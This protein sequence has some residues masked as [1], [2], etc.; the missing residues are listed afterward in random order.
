[1]RHRGPGV[2]TCRRLPGRRG[3]RRRPRWP[4]SRCRGRR[5]PGWKGTR[6]MRPPARWPGRSRSAQRRRLRRPRSSRG[7]GDWVC[8][9][10][11]PNG[12][13]RLRLR[14]AILE[15]VRKV[16][17]MPGCVK[18]PLRAV[19]ERIGPYQFLTPRR[20]PERHPG[21]PVTLGTRARETLVPGRTIAGRQWYRG[22]R[23][24]P[25]PHRKNRAKEASGP[26]R[27]RGLHRPR[28]CLPHVVPCSSLFP[29][30]TLTGSPPTGSSL[31]TPGRRSRTPRP[32]RPGDWYPGT[33][34][35]P[36]IPPRSQRSGLPCS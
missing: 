1:V 15:A 6:Q 20:C 8:S 23:L 14:A 30:L 10:V 9:W 3:R 18:A 27:G 12:R 2:R 28:R 19:A 7:D 34:H 17:A 5:L 33:S 29:L 13:D 35:P 25:P 36:K 21:S 16:F 11:L 32:G 26:E 22:T 31:F 24:T 4:G